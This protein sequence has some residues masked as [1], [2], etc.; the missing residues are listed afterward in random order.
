[1][2]AIKEEEPPTPQTIEEDVLLINQTTLNECRVRLP[3]LQLNEFLKSFNSSNQEFCVPSDAEP[4]VT[5]AKT[6][7]AITTQESIYKKYNETVIF[8]RVECYIIFTLH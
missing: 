5:T 4:Q 1:M 8:T 3:H 2:G 6:T 7:T